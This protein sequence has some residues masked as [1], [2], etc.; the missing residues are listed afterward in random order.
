MWRV[1][2]V[3]Q[4]TPFARVGFVNSVGSTTFAGS[5]LRQFIQRVPQNIH[6]FCRSG[7]LSSLGGGPETL[8]YCPQNLPFRPFLW[9]ALGPQVKLLPCRV[10]PVLCCATPNRAVPCRAK[11]CHCKT[12]HA[13]PSQNV[14]FHALRGPSFLHMFLI[15][16]CF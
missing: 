11:T 4:S 1:G 2:G 13:V 9:Y 15:V 10:K 3:K 8:V 7:F 6:S 12:C 5:R 16:L 14:P